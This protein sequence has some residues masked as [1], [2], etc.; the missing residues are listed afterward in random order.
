MIP[1]ELGA[2]VNLTELDLSGNQ[3]DEKIDSPIE[4]ARLN[5]RQY[6]LILYSAVALRC[7]YPIPPVLSHFTFGCQTL[8]NFQE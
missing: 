2:L 6:R 4:Y 7:N 1:P 8:P 5:Y 3:I